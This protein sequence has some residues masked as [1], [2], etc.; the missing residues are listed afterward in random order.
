[1][2]EKRTNIEPLDENYSPAEEKKR[3]KQEKK[4]L[5]ADQKA[6]KKEAKRLAREIEAKEDRIY[7]DEASGG[8][9]PVFIITIF[10]I[11]IWLAILALVIR[12][13]IGGVGSNIF[14]PLLKDVPGLNRI[15]PEGGLGDFPSDEVQEDGAYRTLE[16]A[17]SQ[18]KTLEL[19]LEQEQL[20]RQ[21]ER[22][23]I[24]LLQAEVE[25]L[26]TFEDNQVEFQRIKEEFYN[27]VIY[28]EQGPGADAYL[29][30]FESI[31]P[32]T[33]ETLYKQVVA[34]V[35]AEKEVQDYA[36]AY[37]A[38]KPKEAAA[39]FEAMTDNL[40]LAAKILDAMSDDD[41]GKILGAMDS[42]VA[43]RITK[44]MDP[45]VWN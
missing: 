9:M 38:M 25:R 17:L 29:K 2:A 10:I 13:D 23:Q 36:S 6:Q 11:L 22:E 7:D 31:D 37:A 15:L 1:M 27:E 34:Q 18:I 8:G 40:E 16:E 32:A 26:K 42:E 24:E 30:Y 43:A 3:I 44:I 45:A 14:T 4:Q 20:S 41:R 33:A 12:L 35:Q 19:Q 21:S 28:A 5:K 39:I